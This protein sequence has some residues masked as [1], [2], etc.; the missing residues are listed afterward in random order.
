MCSQTSDSSYTTHSIMFQLSPRQDLKELE[1][2]IP[3]YTPKEVEQIS[4][5]QPVTSSY[6]YSGWIKLH[7]ISLKKIDKSKN[8]IKK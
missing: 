7:A 3:L 8:Y 1:M 6:K 2:D 4:A 5:L